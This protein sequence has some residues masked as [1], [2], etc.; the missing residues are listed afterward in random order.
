MY[1]EYYSALAQGWKGRE[2]ILPQKALK[3]RH[4]GPFLRAKS[5]FM[6]GFVLG[7]KYGLLQALFHLSTRIIKSYF[8][9]LKYAFLKALFLH[10]LIKT[11]KTL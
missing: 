8:S 1:T 7:L 10:F 6:E 11:D 3:I 4:K 2:G 5:V 9:C